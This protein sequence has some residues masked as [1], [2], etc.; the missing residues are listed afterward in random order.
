V[1][2][3]QAIAALAHGT[4]TVVHVSADITKYNIRP[5][6]SCKEINNRSSDNLYLNVNVLGIK[7]I[8]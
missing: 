5:N 2:G 3:A 1:G 7:I 8:W 4:E 6:D